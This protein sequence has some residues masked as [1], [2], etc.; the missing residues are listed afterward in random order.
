MPELNSK[1]LKDITPEVV[2]PDE[3]KVKVAFFVGDSLNYF[4][5]DAGLD[6]IEVLK[7][8]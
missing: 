2:K 3:V 4:Y 5:P 7:E 1:T 6:V 8:K